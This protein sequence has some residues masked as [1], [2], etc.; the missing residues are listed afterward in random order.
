MRRGGGVGERLGYGTTRGLAL[1][2]HGGLRDDPW[3]GLATGRPVDQR[4]GRTA[5]YGTSRR[6][7]GTTSDL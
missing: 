7:T 2:E 1:R 5:D 6:P 3:T 4:P